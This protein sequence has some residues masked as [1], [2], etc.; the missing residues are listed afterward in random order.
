MTAASD[1]CEAAGRTASG[2]LSAAIVEARSASTTL[3]ISG[4][5]GVRLNCLVRCGRQHHLPLDRQD[6]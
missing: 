3:K 2:F 6:F 4:A 5:K 1:C